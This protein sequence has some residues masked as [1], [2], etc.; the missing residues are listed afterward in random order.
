MS[1]PL[2]AALL[3]LSDHI[4][5]ISPESVRRILAEDFENDPGFCGY[6]PADYR[7]VHAQR[8]VLLEMTLSCLGCTYGGPEGIE[9]LDEEDF[10]DVSALVE[11]ILAMVRS[12]EDR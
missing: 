2:L 4:F 10:D 12:L 11:M 5:T 3:R 6:N 1:R 8:K 7:T 9:E